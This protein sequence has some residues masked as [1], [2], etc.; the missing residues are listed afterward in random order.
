MPLKALYTIHK[1]SYPH[2]HGGKMSGM[3]PIRL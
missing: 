2:G 1:R 3:K